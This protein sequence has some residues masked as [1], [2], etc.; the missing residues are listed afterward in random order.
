[1]APRRR[2]DQP[3]PL[4]VPVPLLV[5]ADPPDPMMVVTVACDAG[6]AGGDE[7]GGGVLWVAGAAGVPW[8]AGAALWAGLG[9]GLVFLAGWRGATSFAGEGTVAT[10][11]TVALPR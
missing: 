1:M 7:A 11:A 2:P 4:V 9:L 5:T 10:A 3:L 6:A 8:V